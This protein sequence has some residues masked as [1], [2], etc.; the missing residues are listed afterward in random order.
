MAEYQ[1]KSHWFKTKPADNN[2]LLEYRL[3][4]KFHVGLMQSVKAEK[5]KSMLVDFSDL[6]LQEPALGPKSSSGTVSV[7]V[8]DQPHQMIFS[9][10]F[11]ETSIQ[12][13]E[14]YRLKIGEMTN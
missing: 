1:H 2:L 10:Y 7:H 14:I 12:Y 4:R 8:R 5:C 3:C 11:A 13:S 6:T 9:C